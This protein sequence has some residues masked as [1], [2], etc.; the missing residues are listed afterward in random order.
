MAMKVYLLK[1]EDFEALLTAL[2]RD[3]RWGEKGGTSQNQSPEQSS[4]T[5]EAH[6]FY[7][8]HIRTWIDRVK[9]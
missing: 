2:D 3:P 7:N 5:A 4:A 8:Y 6:R 1:E 9:R